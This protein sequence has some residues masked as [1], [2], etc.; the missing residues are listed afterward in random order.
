M[1]F[2]QEKKIARKAAKTLLGAGYHLGVHDGEETTVTAT[3]DLE[4][5]MGALATTDMDNLRVFR[6]NG[7]RVGTVLLIW[8]NGEDL[9][10]DVGAPN[11]AALDEI[12]GV[13]REAFA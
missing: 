9:I 4:Q 3:T 2:E 11:D 6:P 8:G 5:V 12:E 10:S 13:I 7:E 1:S